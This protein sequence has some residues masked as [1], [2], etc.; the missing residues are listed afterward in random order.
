[1]FP[2]H[3]REDNLRGF[4]TLQNY[5]TRVAPQKMLPPCS[6]TLASHQGFQACTPKVV[7]LGFGILSRN[8]SGS[9]RRGLGNRDRCGLVRLI[10]RARLLVEQS[11]AAIKKHADS[12]G[13]PLGKGHVPLKIQSSGKGPPQNRNI[14]VDAQSGPDITSAITGA[15]EA[16]SAASGSLDSAWKTKCC[17]SGNSP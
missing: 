6:S 17:N 4:Y 12:C 5:P 14:L 16:G 9:L 10:S 15:L 7:P 13:M 3:F 1:M 11:I 8:T 2:E